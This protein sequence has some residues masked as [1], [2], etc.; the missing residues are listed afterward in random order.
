MRARV[1]KCVEEK[2]RIEKK[3][4]KHQNGENI[5]YT[6]ITITD[7]IILLGIC[8]H[9]PVKYDTIHML[10][11]TFIVD[12]SCI[13]I[14]VIARRLFL[15]QQIIAPEIGVR[16]QSHWFDWLQQFLDN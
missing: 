9:L 11:I 14:G 16:Y 7:I 10:V 15:H 1:R 12:A 5:K 13:G 8:N 3:T 6:V 4:V 2:E